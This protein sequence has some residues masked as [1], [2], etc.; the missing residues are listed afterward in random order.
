[1]GAVTVSFMLILEHLELRYYFEGWRG[2]GGAGSFENFFFF[3][4]AF[5][6]LYYFPTVLQ[7]VFAAELK[8]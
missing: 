2:G 4:E 8:P 6:N 3:Q 7:A 1:M 5:C